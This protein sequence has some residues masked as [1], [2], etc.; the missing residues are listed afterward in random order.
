MVNPRALTAAAGVAAA[1]VF[2]SLS[3]MGTR[4]PPSMLL[5]APRVGVRSSFRPMAV[6]S[7]VRSMACEAQNAARRSFM[8]GGV[9][10]VGTLIAIQGDVRAEAPFSGVVPVDLL[11]PGQKDQQRFRAPR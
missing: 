10:T 2:V 11:T 5:R 8:L 3:L 1:L 6:S 4:S 9:G 7:G